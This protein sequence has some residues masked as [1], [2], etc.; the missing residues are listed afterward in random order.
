[1]MFIGFARGKMPI[2][3]IS[4]L[5]IAVIAVLTGLNVLAGALVALLVDQGLTA[6][7]AALVVA[8]GFVLAAAILCAV[9]VRMLKSISLMPTETISALKRDARTLKESFHD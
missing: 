9:G 6:G 5:T 8:G 1:M 2:E 7:W 3:I 4:L